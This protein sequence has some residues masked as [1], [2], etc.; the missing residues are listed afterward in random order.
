MLAEV[1][2][3]G[4]FTVSSPGTF[5]SIGS[6]P[7]PVTGDEGFS[8]AATTCSVG[9]SIPAGSAVEGSSVRTEEIPD[10]GSAGTVSLTGVLGDIV[11]SS[12]GEVGNSAELDDFNGNLNFLESA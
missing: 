4:D 11:S 1:S 5:S 7:E 10:G 8:S 9:S 2:C 6:G 3:G 12:T